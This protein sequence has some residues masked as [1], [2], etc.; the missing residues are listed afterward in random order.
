MKFI[1]LF[2]MF[3]AFYSLQQG[4]SLSSVAWF[5]VGAALAVSEM[6]GYWIKAEIRASY[7]N[8]RPPYQSL[9]R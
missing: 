5:I 8:R 1:G 6:I 7:R 4:F 3:I 9:R 2:L